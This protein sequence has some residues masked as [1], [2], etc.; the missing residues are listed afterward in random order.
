MGG[1]KLLLRKSKTK[2]DRMLLKGYAIPLKASETL[3]IYKN[4]YFTNCIQK[5]AIS[6]AAITKKNI[7]CSTIRGWYK[8]LKVKDFCVFDF[9]ELLFF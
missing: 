9:I 2:S 6:M 3:Y 7:F 1:L 8:E 5:T 4:I